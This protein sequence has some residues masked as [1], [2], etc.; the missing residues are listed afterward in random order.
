MDRPGRQGPKLGDDRGQ[1][2]VRIFPRIPGAPAAESKTDPSVIPESPSGR[3]GRIRGDEASPKTAGRQDPLWPRQD[4]G[5]QDPPPVVEFLEEGRQGSPGSA[6][7]IEGGTGT[8]NRRHKNPGDGKDPEIGKKPFD[9]ICLQDGNGSR[10]GGPR[11][12]RKA[13]T[14]SRASGQSAAPMENGKTHVESDGV[15]AAVINISREISPLVPGIGP[16]GGPD[17]N[18]GRGV[19]GSRSH[20]EGDERIIRLERILD[21]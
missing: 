7:Q 11:P 19:H 2:L 12:T 18:A 17:I 14:P 16:A 10:S 5:I 8:G 20:R 6:H 3:I 21:P 1:V 13:P 15:Q 9:R 4:A